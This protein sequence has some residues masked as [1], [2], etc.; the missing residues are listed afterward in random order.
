MPAIAGIRR[1]MGSNRQNR[2]SD[3]LSSNLTQ[4]DSYPSTGSSLPARANAADRILGRR[5]KGLRPIFVVRTAATLPRGPLYDCF[6]I[7][8]YLETLPDKGRWQAIMDLSGSR[9]RP[10]P[11]CGAPRSR[12][13]NCIPWGRLRLPDRRRQSGLGCRRCKKRWIGRLCDRLRA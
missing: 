1:N 2:T 11:P 7:G 10:S 13:R 8:N 12:R 5:P 4:A 9:V 3:F 6:F